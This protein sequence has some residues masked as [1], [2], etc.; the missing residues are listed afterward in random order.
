MKAKAGHLLSICP[1]LWGHKEG[2]SRA[3]T[4]PL[5]TQFPSFPGKP[6][7]SSQILRALQEA[8]RNPSTPPSEDVPFRAPILTQ[9]TSQHS[10]T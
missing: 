9:A 10:P 1:K 8:L 6:R 3:G 7:Q 2:P 5:A 4:V